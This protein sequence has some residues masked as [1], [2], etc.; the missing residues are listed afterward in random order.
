MT[1]D[2]VEGRPGVPAPPVI[3]QA[4]LPQAG[5]TGGLVPPF[6]PGGGRPAAWSSQE[7]EAEPETVVAAMPEI[8]TAANEEVEPWTPEELEADGPLPWEAEAEA[9]AQAEEAEAEEEGWPELPE[10]GGGVVSAWGEEEEEE[11]EEGEAGGADQKAFPLDAFFVPTDSSRVPSGYDE[12]EH[13]RIVDGVASQLEDLAHAVRER[14]IGALGAASATDDL[15]RL[16]A[17]VVAGYYARER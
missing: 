14:G 12:D 7:Q 6:V 5:M 16:I 3:T 11:E 10:A 13:R 2:A 8:R 15:S 9:E 17:A 1:S 4:V